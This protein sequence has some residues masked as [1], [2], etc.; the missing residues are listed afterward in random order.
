[1]MCSW[2]FVLSRVKHEKKVITS[3]PAHVAL[4]FVVVVFVF[5]FDCACPFLYN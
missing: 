3:G 2:N 5:V 1:M 4:F